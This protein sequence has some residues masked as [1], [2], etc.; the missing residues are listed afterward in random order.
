M[1]KNDI[2]KI[3]IMNKT[4]IKKLETV[5]QQKNENIMM[6]NEELEWFIRQN[7][8]LKKQLNDRDSIINMMEMKMV[9]NNKDVS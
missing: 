9:Q 2:R 1:E 7:Y 5:I 3:D 8:N 6:I 4:T